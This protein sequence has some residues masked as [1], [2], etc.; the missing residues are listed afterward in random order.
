LKIEIVKNFSFDWWKLRTIVQLATLTRSL[1][2]MSLM[3]PT[4]AT[5]EEL[6]QYH[7]EEYIKSSTLS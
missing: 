7:T 1:N 4:A 2:K 6:T 3:A 5:K